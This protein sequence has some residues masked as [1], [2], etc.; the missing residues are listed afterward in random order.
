MAYPCNE[1]SVLIMYGI[2]FQMSI[3]T[4]MGVKKIICL[5]L[6]MI[7][8]YNLIFLFGGILVFHVY[9]L[10]LIIIWLD[11]WFLC[12]FLA[13]SMVPMSSPGWIPGSYV[14]PWLDPRFLCHVLAGSLVPM[15]SPGWIPGTYVKSWL[16]LWLP[17]QVLI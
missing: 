6:V 14:K 3:H 9:L 7:T 17:C 8:Y 16:D 11:L 1:L 12:Q 15:S 5:H 13:G 4:K 2:F 10:V